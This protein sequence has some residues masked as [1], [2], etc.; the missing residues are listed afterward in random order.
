MY[1]LTHIM[2][3]RCGV[4]CKE[5]ASR[6][7]TVGVQATQWPVTAMGQVDHSKF[8]VGYKWAMSGLCNRSHRPYNWWL[9][10][11]CSHAICYRRKCSWLRMAST[12]LL[13]GLQVIQKLS[14][15]MHRVGACH[16]IRC[17]H[18]IFDIVP[19]CIATVSLRLLP[20]LKC[21]TTIS[22]KVCLYAYDNAAI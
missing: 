6:M 10:S 12:L 2:P 3:F 15:S 1:G 22:T 17:V 16:L 13:F 4:D 20:S 19:K 7:N 5:V 18:A 14:K 21:T 8:R 11:K 9:Y